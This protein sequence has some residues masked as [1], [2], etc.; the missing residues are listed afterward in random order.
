MQKNGKC[1]NGYNFSDEIRY[2][3]NKLKSYNLREQELNEISAGKDIVM[4]SQARTRV[5]VEDIQDILRR[6]AAFNHLD[7][8][9]IDFY[10]DGKKLEIP[11]SLINHFHFTGLANIDFIA[12]DFYKEDP[13]IFDKFR[14]ES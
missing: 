9:D 7:L 1:H 11:N 5:D 2:E 4:E 3:T 8:N 13:K 14:E 12:S 10:E 6:R